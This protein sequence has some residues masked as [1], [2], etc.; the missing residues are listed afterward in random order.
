MVTR[1]GQNVDL[2]SGQATDLPV[3]CRHR[4]RNPGNENLVFIE[5]QRGDYLAEEDIERSE[6]D[7]G[8][9]P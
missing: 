9:V 7:Y 8:R 1:N 4:V 6:D 5:V 3:K 2:S